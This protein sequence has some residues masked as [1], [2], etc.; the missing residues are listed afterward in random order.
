MIT[1]GT[2]FLGYVSLT[3]GAPGPVA[4]SIFVEPGGAALTLAAPQRLYVT[5]VAISSNDSAQ[6]KVVIDTGGSTPTT[7][8]S[9]YASNTAPPAVEVIP[10]GVGRCIP[11]VVP[12]ASASAVTLGKTVEV[13]LAGFI[14]NT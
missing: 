11:G 6:P 13:T 5:N 12:R 8:S 14:S 10:P 4:F 9:F 1:Q 7:I 3:N 2:P